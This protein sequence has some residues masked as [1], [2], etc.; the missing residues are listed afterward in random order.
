[1]GVATLAYCAVSP[2]NLQPLSEYNRH[3]YDNL[4]LVAL[5]TI[6]PLANF[7]LVCDARE[8][9]INSVVRLGMD[10]TCRKD[11]LLC[12]MSARSYFLTPVIAF[13]FI[14]LPPFIL[15]SL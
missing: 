13:C 14:R 1:M 6:V 3:F 9:D 5:C 7:L 15:P 8:N 4:R 2:R 12:L 11:A 10:M